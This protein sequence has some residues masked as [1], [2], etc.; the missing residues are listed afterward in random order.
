M[1]R[2]IGEGGKIHPHFYVACSFDTKNHYEALI[3]KRTIKSKSLNIGEVSL[4]VLKEVAYKQRAY[5]IKE[6][7][8]LNPNT[9]HQSLFLLVARIKGSSNLHYN[10]IALLW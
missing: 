4:S 10:K 6:N 1:V 7:L 5:D 3:D 9:S 2:T 8:C